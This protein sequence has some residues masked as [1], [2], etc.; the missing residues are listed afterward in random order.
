MVVAE[1]ESE[2]AKD[3]MVFINCLMAMNRLLNLLFHLKENR[4]WAVVSA[5]QTMMFSASALTKITSFSPHLASILGR[6]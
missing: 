6:H 2:H 4:H 1:S 5:E 3:C